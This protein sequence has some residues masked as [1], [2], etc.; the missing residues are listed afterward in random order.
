VIVADVEF[1][2]LLQ[3][4]RSGDESAMARL[5]ERYEPEVRIVARAKLGAALRPHLDS[6][7]LVQSV[8]RSLIVGLRAE[9]FDISTPENLIALALTIVRRKVA[10][11]WRK[12]KRQQRLAEGTDSQNLPD[13]LGEIAGSETDPAQ[14][15]AVQEATA[16][17]IAQLDESERRVIE[18]R[19][20]GHTTAEVARQLQLDPDVLRV[21][22][23]RLRRRLRERGLLEEW[24]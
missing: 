1:D 5:V 7:D 13:M 14:H 11:H 17:L 8:H 21:K 16:Q 9:R 24:L 10:R 18:L 19:L 4:A 12:L 6:V 3:Q 23:S 15:A 20:E 22:L 2:Q